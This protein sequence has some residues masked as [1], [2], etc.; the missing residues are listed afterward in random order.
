MP[1]YEY[2]C[3]K[4]RERVE[5]FQKMSDAPLVE[6]PKCGG[7][8]KRVFFPIPVHYK[9]SG[10]HTTDY[11]KKTSTQPGKTGDK[12]QGESSTEGGGDSGAPAETK[13]S[14]GGTSATSA[15]SAKP[16]GPKKPDPA[17]PAAD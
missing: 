3:R 17:K 10:F 16:E 5:T 14:D 2:E 4:C 8:L 6:C 11:A 1:T 9:G 13:P 12:P 15:D 7:E